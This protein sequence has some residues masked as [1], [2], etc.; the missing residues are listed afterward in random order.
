MVGRLCSL[1]AV[2]WEETDSPGGT[3]LLSSG[4]GLDN[5]VKLIALDPGAKVPKHDHSC[6]EQVYMLSG[7]LQTEGRVIGPGDFFFRA[8]AGTHHHELSSPDGCV[9]V[10]ILAPALAV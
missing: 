5:K 8:E 9:A 6:T 10:V 4:P 7:H 3:K 1:K 2:G